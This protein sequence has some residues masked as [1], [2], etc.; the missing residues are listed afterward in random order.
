MYFSQDSLDSHFNR[1][2]FMKSYI[3]LSVL[4]FFGWSS[5]VPKEGDIIDSLNGVAVYYNGGVSNVFGR[6]VTNDGY[7]LGLK[8]QCVEF[9]KRYYYEVFNH[10]MPNSYGHAKE[11]FDDN[12]GDA[13]FNE[14]RNLMQYRNTRSERPQVHDLLVYGS[15]KDNSF[16]HVAIISSVTDNYVEIVQQNMGNKSRVRLQ[17]VNFE[18]IYTIADFNIKGWLRKI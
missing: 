3:I 9:V 14:Q 7:N 6:N 16:G 13:E 4:L 10:K 18:G 5:N 1:N 8:W 17:L 15:S 12:L 11:F 2:L